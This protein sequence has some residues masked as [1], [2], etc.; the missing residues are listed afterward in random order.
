VDLQSKKLDEVLQGV[1]PPGRE[2]NSFCSYNTIGYREQA[3]AQLEALEPE[4]IRARKEGRAFVPRPIA[5][6]FAK[7]ENHNGHALLKF[8]GQ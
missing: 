4:R 3:R 5:F 1:P 6:E 8:S 2:A 7:E